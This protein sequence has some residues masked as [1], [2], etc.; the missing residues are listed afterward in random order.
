ML[1]TGLQVP[2]EGFPVVAQFRQKALEPFSQGRE[3]IM[4]YNMELLQLATRL[5][6]DDAGMKR[7]SKVGIHSIMYES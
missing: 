5:P 1:A 2:L 3:M 4:K 6:F 7:L